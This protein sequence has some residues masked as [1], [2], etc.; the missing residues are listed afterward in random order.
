[1]KPS[2]QLKLSQHLALTPQLQQSIRLLQLS[3][4]ELEQELEKYLLDNPL[5]ERQ[6]DYRTPE[7]PRDE[8]NADAPAEA[9]PL[10]SKANTLR[11]ST[12]AGW[13][14]RPPAGSSGSFDDDDDGDSDYQDIQAAT[15]SLREHLLAQLGLMTLSD[16]DRVLVRCLVEALDD[17]GYLTQSLAELSEAMPEELEIEP[18]E[19]Q[20]ALKHL[21]HFDPTGVGA[22]SA[23]NVWRCNSKPCR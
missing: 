10:P 4:L 22:R 13:A 15:V 18:E 19:L 3:T 8:G 5:L 20:I 17:D 2:L 6:E 9:E 1:M 11:P 7:T 21:Q 14:T 23:R 16:R 12:T